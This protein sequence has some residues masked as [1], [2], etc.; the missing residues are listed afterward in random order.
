MLWKNQKRQTQGSF[1]H[2]MESLKNGKWVLE[3]PWKFL[4][5]F[6]LKRVRTLLIAVVL[7]P[8]TFFTI[9]SWPWTLS[10]RKRGLTDYYF[11]VEYH[12]FKALENASI[13]VK[14]PEKYWA[15]QGQQLSLPLSCSL[16]A[17]S[18]PTD[19]NPQKGMLDPVFEIPNNMK[20]CFT[21]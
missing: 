15:Q 5:F 3:S 14:V 19:R 7:F 8:N 16:W 10:P 11:N 4:E 2:Q 12:Y 13:T 18:K 20:V 17:S 9:H 6:V 21:L 1:L